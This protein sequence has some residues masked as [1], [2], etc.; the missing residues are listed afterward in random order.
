MQALTLRTEVQRRDRERIAEIGV[1]PVVRVSSPVT[2]CIAADAVAAGGIPIV[3]ITM[4]VPGAID[5]IRDLARNPRGGLLVGAGTVLDVEMAERC[6]VAG[7][8]FLVNPALDLQTIALAAGQGVVMIS[9]ALTP[10]EIVVDAGTPGAAGAPAALAV[11]VHRWDSPVSSVLRHH[12][13]RI[14]AEGQANQVVAGRQ[15]W[16]RR[17]GALVVVERSADLSD[18]VGSGRRLDAAVRPALLVPILQP[19]SPIH[20]GPPVVQ[21]SRVAAAAWLLPP[22]AAPAAQAPRSPGPGGGGGFARPPRGPGGRVPRRRPRRRGPRP[23]PRAGR[24]R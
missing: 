8:R 3:E 12:V 18:V 19:S 23:G 10:T 6:I 9:G 7:A 2:A 21:G 11:R 22:P 20:D 14:H 13:Q 17:V 15:M 24:R 4:T 5:V 1:I 16:R